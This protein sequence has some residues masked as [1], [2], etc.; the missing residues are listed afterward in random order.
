MWS[1]ST[2]QA[3]E[4]PKLAEFAAKLGFKR[5]ALL[6]LNTDWGRTAKDAF[7]KAAPGL[8]ME[9]VAVEGYLA[10]EQ[11]FG[12]PWCAPATASRTGWCC[13]PTMPTAR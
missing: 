11:D 12:R 13:S 2:S 5:P 9:V 10:A 3:D 8:G 6:H 7:V 1:N 4:Q